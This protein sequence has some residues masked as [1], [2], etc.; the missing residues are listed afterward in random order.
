MKTILKLLFFAAC[1]AS[2][3]AHAQYSGPSGSKA[4]VN[5]DTELPA[6][7]T[8]GDNTTNPSTTSTGAFN[9]VFDG[10]TWDRLRGDSS[11]GILVNLG[12]NNDVTISGAI[13]ANAGT[14]L[15]TSALALESGG[16]LATISTNTGSTAT[17][18]GV[19][20]DWDES[21]RA[22]VNPIVG[23]AGVAAGA[24][25]VGAT[26]QRVSVG[27]TSM[28]T[29]GTEDAVGADSYTTIITPSADATHLVASLSGNAD[30]ICSFNAGVT[31]HIVVPA[32]SVIALD[33]ITITSGVA[34]QCK[35]K[36]AG[37]NY[38]NMNISVW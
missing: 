20:D 30:A 38:I 29:R 19:M 36:T 7:S 5:A 8:L 14:N 31:E 17:S 15:N 28:Q 3:V 12:A 24:G 26:T 27:S 2:N 22:K 18:T 25:A 4:T 16:N 1:L 9:F 23:Q 34:I 35:N 33:A 10:S 32:S 6:A 37:A 11:D 21:D 13:T